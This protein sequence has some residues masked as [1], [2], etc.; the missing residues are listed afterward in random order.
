MASGRTL[1]FK[2]FAVD[3]TRLPPETQ[4]M[5]AVERTFRLIDEHFT[6]TLS[7]VPR[8]QDRQRIISVRD[9]ARD[10]YWKAVETQLRSDTTHVQRVRAD[11]KSA[12]RVL[13]ESFGD[14]NDTVRLLQA[15]N[16]AVKLSTSL[17]SLAAG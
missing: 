17:T 12:N 1:Q 4:T 3:E 16:Q 8:N 9:A 11:L 5:L 13:E 7:N 10:A 14:P 2:S 15:M 6:Q